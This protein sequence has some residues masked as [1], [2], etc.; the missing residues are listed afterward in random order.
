MG[1]LTGEPGLHVGGAAEHGLAADEVV[2]VEFDVDHIG[3]HGAIELDR[4]AGRGVVTPVVGGAGQDGVGPVT[5]LHRLGDGGGQRH[6]DQGH[7]RGSP[8]WWMVSSAVLAEGLGQVVGVVA[9]VDTLDG[10]G[11]VSGLGQQ[12][13][14]GRGHLAVGRFGHDP[15]LVNSVMFR[16]SSAASDD[17][18][19]LEVLDDLLR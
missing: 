13:Q 2:A 15:D 4:E 10:V 6:P 5:G 12:F 3:D 9:G 11:Q 14:G 17:L 8:V 19:I 1:A 18:Q 7:R 16:C